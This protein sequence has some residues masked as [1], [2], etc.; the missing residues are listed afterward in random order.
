[1]NIKKQKENASLNAKAA[2]HVFLLNS[3]KEKRG[4]EQNSSKFKDTSDRFAGG[5]VYEVPPEQRQNIID[6]DGVS[7]EFLDECKAAAKK[8]KKII[9]HNNLKVSGKQDSCI[10]GQTLFEHNSMVWHGRP[11]RVSPLEYASLFKWF[12]KHKDGIPAYIIVDMTTQNTE[13]IK[14]P[15]GIKYSQSEHFNRNIYRHLR[16]N[17][18]HTFLTH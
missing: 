15:Q 13:I 6:R 5:H 9:I 11:V 2:G 4:L 14:L 7:K 10:Y 16:F 3:V 1:M 18:P 17:Y 8:Y 12:T